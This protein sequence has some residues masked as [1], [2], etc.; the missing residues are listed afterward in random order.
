MI[1]KRINVFETYKPYNIY[2]STIETNN[3]GS[4]SL[5]VKIENG[6]NEYKVLCTYYTE[7]AILQALIDNKAP[8]K[9]L[10]VKE[11]I[12]NIEYDINYKA[13]KKDKYII[14]DIYFY[15]GRV[16][17]TTLKP[18]RTLEYNL[19]DDV[20]NNL[21]SEENYTLNDKRKVKDIK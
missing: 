8:S 4:L 2:I 5:N 6:Y 15:Y 14:K 3:D 1:N 18:Y 9:Y 19:K 20:M 16:S 21:E 11:D 7:N 13:L 10:S 17:K 12:D